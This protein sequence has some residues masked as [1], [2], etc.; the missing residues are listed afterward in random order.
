MQTTKAGRQLLSELRPGQHLVLRDSNEPGQLLTQFTRLGEVY[1]ILGPGFTWA[2]GN[3][4][5]L[6]DYFEVALHNG[7]TAESA[8]AMLNDFI[9]AHRLPAEAKVH[10]CHGL[11]EALDTATRLF[12]WD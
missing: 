5:D 4:F 9:S 2:F 8:V 3:E 10:T 12:G 1:Y 11:P 7:D 6:H